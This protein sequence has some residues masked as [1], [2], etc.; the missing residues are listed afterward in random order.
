MTNKTKAPVTPVKKP[1]LQGNPTDERTLKGAAGFFGALLLIALMTFIVSSALNLENDILRIL[2]NAAVEAVILLVMYN[3]AVGRGTDAVAR[4]EILYQR[5]E[6][7]REFRESEQAVCFHPLKGYLIG[8]LGTLPLLLCAIVLAII[9]RRQTT[10]IGALPGWLTAFQSRSEVGDALVAYTVTE[11]ITAE[12]ILRVIVRVMVMPF[13]SMAGS[14]NREGLLLVERL[15][16]LLV[17]L[18]AIAYGTGYLQG[19]KEREKILTG[20]AQSNR[21]RARKERRERKARAAK[22]TGP[23]QLN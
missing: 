12:N 6:K 23:R 19:K 15:S 21:N 7:G 8:F 14:E 20:I 13:V 16:P 5:K 10:G 4:G 2:L 22:P 1:F 11:G 18:P 3:N 9:T 17:L